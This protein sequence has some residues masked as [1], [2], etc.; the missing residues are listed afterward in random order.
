MSHWT[1]IT[2][3]ITVEPFGRTQ[4]EMEYILKTV[5]NHLPVVTG[6]ERDMEAHIVKKQGRNCSMNTDEYDMITNNLR[7]DRGHRS[8]MHGL[9]ETQTEYL[10]VVEGDF[11]DRV[12]DETYKEF[13]KWL[14]R[15]A[16]RIIVDDVFVSIEGDF[17]QEKRLIIANKNYDRLMHWPSWSCAGDP[18]KPNWCEHLMW[19]HSPYDNPEEEED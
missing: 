10:V 12:L 4:E 13:Q 2:G 9:L 16:K 17:P 19:R 8:R 3:T 7:T 14:C 1:H 11:R 15:L 18:D 6:S 5:L